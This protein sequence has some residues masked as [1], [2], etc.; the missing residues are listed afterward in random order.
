MTAWEILLGTVSQ[1]LLICIYASSVCTSYDFLSRH[2]E[3]TITHQWFLLP[4][5]PT[6]AVTQYPQD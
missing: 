2:A 6:Q 1:F 5:Y 4:L 3:I